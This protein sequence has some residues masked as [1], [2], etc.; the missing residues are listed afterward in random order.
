M[1]RLATGI[2]ISRCIYWIA[3]SLIIVSGCSQTDTPVDIEDNGIDFVFYVTAD[4]RQ[5]TGEDRDYFRGVCEAIDSLGP[6][7]FMVSP[8]DIDP[9]A[10]VLTTIQTYID[11]DYL[12]YPVVGNHE[13]ET[14]DDMIWLRNYNPN[15]STLPSIVNVGPQGSEETSFSFEY[16]DAHFVV[17]NQYYNGFSD[18]GTDG[19]VVDELHSWLAADLEANEKPITFVMGHEPAYP[20]PDE[21][22]GRLRHEYDSL[23]RHPENRDRFWNTLKRYSV[24]AYICGHTHN[25]SAV[26]I[27]GVWQLDAGH[28]RGTG[29]LGARSTFVLFNVMKDGR[30]YFNAFRLDLVRGVYVV[31]SSGQLH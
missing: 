10:D 31:T 17:L 30:V 29:D 26:N 22:N 13:A 14:A 3:I 5:Y 24:T 27:D 6:G 15:G 28:A 11:E 1:K 18:V 8:G 19:D 7:E 16:H 12:W 4:M 9:P 2:V 25:F 20:Q 23:N 21:E